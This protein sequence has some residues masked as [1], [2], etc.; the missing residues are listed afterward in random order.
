MTVEEELLKKIRSLNRLLQRA[1]AN[2]LVFSDISMLCG[3]LLESNIL[4]AT[5]KG[6]LLDVYNHEMQKSYPFWDCR[7]GEVL[8]MSRTVALNRTLETVEDCGLDKLGFD[9]KGQ[10]IHAVVVPLESS[11]DRI[12]TLIICREDRAYTV[13]D[14]IL[15]EYAA[16]IVGI[17]LT[18]SIHQETE[19]E[20]Q[21]SSI[22]R[23]AI[24]TLSYSELEAVIHIFQELGG[25]E[26]MLVA[27]KIADKVGITRSVIVN[28]L[29]KFES[30][31]I[32]ESRS[33]GMKGTFIRILNPALPDELKKY[34]G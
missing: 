22:C 2:P 32:I 24:S 10:D 29:R 19:K 34:N 14:I 6:K 12:G 28:A 17:E 21:Q 11:G 23:A 1:G 26:G 7:A 15:M 18:R 9:E 25:M 20:E 4:I 16:T 8:E 31:G 3:E 13:S 30:A 5:K 27:S 33:L